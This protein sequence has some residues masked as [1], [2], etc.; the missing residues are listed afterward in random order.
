MKFFEYLNSKGHVEDGVID[1]GAKK[2]DVP[3]DKIKAPEDPQ[4][5]PKP[6]IKAKNIE[7]KEGKLPHVKEY[8]DGKG[9]L[10]EKPKIEL[11]PDVDFNPPAAPPQAKTKGKGWDTKAPAEV[12]KKGA[13]GPANKGTAPKK[14]EAGFAEKGSIPKE[15]IKI[16]QG[17]SKYFPGGEEI[18][19]WEKKTKSEAATPAEYARIS[20][21]QRFKESVSPPIGFEG[22][23][24]PVD[25][26][27]D[28]EENPDIEEGDDEEGQKDPDEEL[29]DEIEE[30][31]DEAGDG[32]EGDDDKLDDE[33]EEEGKEGDQQ[34]AP[35]G[36]QGNPNAGMNVPESAWAKFVNRK[37]KMNE[38]KV[39]SKEC[40]KC[41]KGMPKDSKVCKE[42][43]Y[44]KK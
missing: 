37:D 4:K 10:V 2:V 23:N 13:Y 34:I 1:L 11:V 40:P 27:E 25:G 14:G 24:D 12:G 16:K 41:G 44:G 42:C 21:L 33:G 31:E 30:L 28:S 38:G 6:K 35:Q 32:E 3:K 43:G 18:E 15:E 9:K 5:N 36:A 8:L 29:D 26:V 7:D 22:E 19:G 20:F 17:A 39:N